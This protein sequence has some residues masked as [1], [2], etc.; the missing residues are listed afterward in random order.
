MDHP[1][2]RGTN[3]YVMMERSFHQGSPPLARDKLSNYQCVGYV[4]GITPA[5]AG[6]MN[7]WTYLFF[8]GGIT[9]ACAGQI[10]K[11]V[12]SWFVKW[13]HPRLRGTNAIH[14][15]DEW[16]YAGSPPLARDK[17][18]KY[19][20][21]DDSQGITPACAGQIERLNRAF[22]LIE[23]H[24]RLRGTNPRKVISMQTGNGSPPLARDKCRDKTMRP[25]CI[26]ITPACAGQI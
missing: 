14:E 1:R 17:L 4:E 19:N 15:E 6:Q 23:D 24:P 16:P 26:G 9:P 10:K 18:A 22:N 21:L 13:D 20:R 2:L 25:Y 12:L 5:C 11:Q 3:K 8:Q 7:I